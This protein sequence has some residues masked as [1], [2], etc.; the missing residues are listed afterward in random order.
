MKCSDKALKEK[1]F[2]AK[3]SRGV[4]LKICSLGFTW[5]LKCRNNEIFVKFFKYFGDFPKRIIMIFI[6]FRSFQ[7]IFELF[8]EIS[9]YPEKFEPFQRNFKLSKEIWN[10]PE[11]I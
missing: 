4:W 3:R 8:R 2:R 5:F 7:K 9:N 6:K 1:F 11:K 10:C